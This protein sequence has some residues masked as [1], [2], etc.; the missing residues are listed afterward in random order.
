MGIK[1]ARTAVPVVAGSVKKLYKERAAGRSR[2]ILLPRI[3]L[4]ILIRAKLLHLE[5]TVWVVLLS[6]LLPTAAGWGSKRRQY[7]EWECGSRRAAEFRLISQQFSSSS[8][9]AP[10][11]RSRLMLDP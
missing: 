10:M 9:P 8:I 4:T 7:R 11:A 5:D 3:A 1:H 6:C 2:V